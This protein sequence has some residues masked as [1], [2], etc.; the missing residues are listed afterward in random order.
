MMRHDVGDTLRNALVSLEDERERLDRQIAALKEALAMTRRQTG[1]G[2]GRR[3]LGAAQEM[4]MAP[5]R[6]RRSRM[7]L[8]ARRATS[9]RM[10]AFWAKRR[11]EKAKAE[12]AKSKAA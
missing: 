10:K 3:A 1:R 7:S 4:G 9:R 2:V 12:K 6:R 8:A 5:R 11:A